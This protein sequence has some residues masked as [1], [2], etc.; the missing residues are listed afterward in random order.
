MLDEKELHQIR[1]YLVQ[2]LPDLL[3]QEPEIATTIEGILAQHFPRR[4]EFAHLLDEIRLL[5]EETR[6][7]FLQ[8][9][10]RFE[11]LRQEMN[12]RFAQMDQGFNQL[13]HNLLEVRRDVAQLQHGQERIL[14][15][16]D[17]QEAWLRYVSGNLRAE[18][19][20]TMEDLVAVAL[21]YG[22]KHPDIQPESIRLRQKLVDVDGMVF[23]R[24]FATEVD[25][26][27]EDG[28]LTVFEVKT[29][30]KASDAGLFALK[31]ELVAA[32]NPDKQ[33]RG[34]LITLASYPELSQQC[35]EYGL[36]LVDTSR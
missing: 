5:R 13:G 16:I 14:D 26:M 25:V 21:S 7:R 36:E 29:T 30:A 19:G 17:H 23:K 22:L 3:R 35:K 4:D 34:V 12:Y 32:L 8:V 1:T 33:V 15:R 6:E 24:G 9:D 10:E 11:F 2:V 31:V 28:R 18:K 20:Q 27:A